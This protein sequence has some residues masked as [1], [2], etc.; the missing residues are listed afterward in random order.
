MVHLANKG[1]F[2]FVPEDGYK[3]KGFLFNVGSKR[4]PE[5]VFPAAPMEDV[6]YLPSTQSRPV[7][8]ETIRVLN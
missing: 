2:R 4:K 5:R 3:G 1:L 7:L 6:F 8:L